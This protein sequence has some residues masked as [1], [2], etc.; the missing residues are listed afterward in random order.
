MGVD[1]LFPEIWK[2]SSKFSEKLKNVV[3]YFTFSMEYLTLIRLVKLIYASEFYSMDQFDRR[4]TDVRFYRWHYGPWSPDVEYTGTIIAGDEILIEE[5]ETKEGYEG[6]FFIPNVER[7]TI[8]LSKEEISILKNVVNEWKYVPTKV[9]TECC[10][11]T[12][13]FQ[14]VNWGKEINLSKYVKEKTLARV[15]KGKFKIKVLGFDV[16]LEEEEMGYSAK[17]PVLDGCFSQGEDIEEV[18]ENIRDAI[19]GYLECKVE[20]E[21]TK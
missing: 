8:D 14:D 4:L 20:H 10:K 7:V 13:P 11:L 21:K 6:S 12:T 18:R 2:K 5:K 17:C 3:I 19:I 1:S 9:L 16:I 15:G